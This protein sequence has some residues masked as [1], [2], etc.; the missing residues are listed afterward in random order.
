MSRTERVKANYNRLRQAG[1]T[2][3]EARKLRS[4]TAEEIEKALAE[5]EVQAQA[6]TREEVKAEKGKGNK[7]WRLA[8]DEIDMIKVI[9][10]VGL[11][12]GE[13]LDILEEQIKAWVAMWESIEGDAGAVM[14]RKTRGML[15]AVQGRGKN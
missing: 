7:A 9:R 14:A 6:E 5:R 2:A 13:V 8:A 12:P 15:E 3:D 4:K 1:F 10:E 11:R